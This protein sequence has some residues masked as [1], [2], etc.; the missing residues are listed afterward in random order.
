M[1]ENIFC[2]FLSFSDLRPAIVLL[3]SASKGWGKV[4]FKVCSALRVEGGV[5]QSTSQSPQ[6]LVPDPFCLGV[7]NLWSHVPSGSTPVSLVPCPFWGSTPVLSQVLL[8]VP[9]PVTDPAGGGY[10]RKGVTPALTWVP[11]ARIGVPPG[12]VTQLTFPAGGLLCC[13]QK[14]FRVKCFCCVF[15]KRRENFQSTLSLDVTP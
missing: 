11:P 3:P 2:I 7:P 12:Q 13:L 15:D 4:M 1:L 6:T 10:P 14:T 5:P 9:N 8:G